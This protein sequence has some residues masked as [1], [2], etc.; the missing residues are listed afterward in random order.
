MK[1]RVLLPLLLL[2]AACGG[3]GGSSSSSNTN[4]TNPT[5]SVDPVTNV[6]KVKVEYQDYCGNKTASHDARLIIHNADFTNKEVIS[7]DEYGVMVYEA[8]SDK[9]NVS[10]VY[11]GFTDKEGYVQ[12]RVKTLMEQPLLDIGSITLKTEDRT[13]CHCEDVDLKV[14]STSDLLTGDFNIKVNALQKVSYE[15]TETGV[16]IKGYEACHVNSQGFGDKL[17]T[18]TAPNYGGSV[19][20]YKKGYQPSDILTTEYQGESFLF[21]VIGSNS[22]FRIYETWADGEL[23]RRDFL[24]NDSSPF[25]YYPYNSLNKEYIAGWGYETVNVDLE[26]AVFERYV[27]KR[28]DPLGDN[29]IILPD[30]SS[31]DFVNAIQSD[32]SSYDFSAYTDFD[33]LNM[34]VIGREEDDESLE[35]FWQIIMPLKGQFPEF[36]HLDIENIIAD[37]KLKT[38]VNLISTSIALEGYQEVNGY[39][40]YI[41]NNHTEF[42]FLAD[43]TRWD[44]FKSVYFGV[45]VA[46]AD[47]D[48]PMGNIKP[49]ANFTSQAIRKIQMANV[50]ETIQPEKISSKLNGLPRVKQYH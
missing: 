48:I 14:D 26:N 45:D 9:A 23:F 17:V 38:N 27:S 30:L 37:W 6:L 25:Y 21:N 19:A 31:D 2:T 1:K 7:P 11:P 8:E 49:L 46:V 15:S 4:P 39:Q 41:T 22:V 18:I 40:D 36:S 16:L 43:E 42:K 47:I 20:A 35:F 32:F 44:E 33:F 10:I 24:W 5:T 29:D 3:G 34:E 28:Y 50:A 13:L 12:L